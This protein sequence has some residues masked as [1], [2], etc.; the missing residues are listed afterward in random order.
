M[1]D[2][3]IFACFGEDVLNAFQSA[4]KATLHTPDSRA[5]R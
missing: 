5:A 3:V 2:Q 4:L 1:I